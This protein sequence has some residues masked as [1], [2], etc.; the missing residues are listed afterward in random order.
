MH[1]APLGRLRCPP[2]GTMLLWVFPLK[3][4][5]WM[6][7]KRLNPPLV[8]PMNS[9]YSVHKAAELEHIWTG[10]YWHLQGIC[11]SDRLNLGLTILTSACCPD[12]FIWSELKKQTKKTSRAGNKRWLWMYL[13]SQTPRFRCPTERSKTTMLSKNHSFK[14]Q[15]WFVLDLKAISLQMQ[16]KL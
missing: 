16:L 13:L 6:Q 2:P 4:V 14:V 5:C 15:T 7:L 10:L 8:P 12:T 3:C 1:R 9:N 11:N